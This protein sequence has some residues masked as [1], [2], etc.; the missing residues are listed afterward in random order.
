MMMM[1]MMMTTTSMIG[2]MLNDPA[3]AVAAA[4][5]DDDRDV[6][7]S[8]SVMNIYEV[9]SPHF[10]PCTKPNSHVRPFVCQ[11]EQRSEEISY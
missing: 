1:M 10:L 8:C 7:V 6:T 5:D 2:V 11:G 4:A 9:I 3:A